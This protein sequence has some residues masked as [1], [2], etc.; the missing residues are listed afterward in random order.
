MSPPKDRHGI[1]GPLTSR[2]GFNGGI[3]H[4]NFLF[5]ED[6]DDDEFKE[7]S[8][9]ANNLGDVSEPKRGASPRNKNDNFFDGADN[10][11][12]SADD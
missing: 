4:T 12:F 7:F 5:T 10:S 8:D 2:A 1:N 3:K 11:V 6:M 9:I